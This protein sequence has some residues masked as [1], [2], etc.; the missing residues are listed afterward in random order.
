MQ[1]Q[2]Q[3]EQCMHNK[4]IY[5]HIITITL[6][7]VL[8]LLPSMTIIYTHM[9]TR[10]TLWDGS[11]KRERK[12]MQQILGKTFATKQPNPKLFSK[13]ENAATNNKHLQQNF[14]YDAH[15]ASVHALDFASP[16]SLVHASTPP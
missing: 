5:Q 8:F 9:H 16:S 10:Y 1:Y 13:D 11:R 6:R 14:Q 12:V 7:I 3:R 4:S 15:H 2:A